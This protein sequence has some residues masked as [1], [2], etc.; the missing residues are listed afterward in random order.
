MLLISFLGITYSFEYKGKSGLSFE[1]IGPST[2]YINVG[3]FYKEDGV[4]VINKGIDISSSVII[5]SS[6]ILNCLLKSKQYSNF[7]FFALFPKPRFRRKT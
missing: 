4:K 7:A 1:L 2:L 3:G 6:S 5:D